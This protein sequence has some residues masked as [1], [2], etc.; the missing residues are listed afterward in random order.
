MMTASVEFDNRILF[1]REQSIE[2]V[3]VTECSD[4]SMIRT[5]SV[6]N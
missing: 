6:K 1:Q 5:Q 4:L 3:S 2:D